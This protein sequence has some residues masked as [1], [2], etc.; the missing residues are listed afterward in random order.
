MRRM[1]IRLLT[2]ECRRCGK[3]LVTASWTLPGTEG[4]KARLDRIC[5]DC[6]TDAERRE[7]EQAQAAAVLNGGR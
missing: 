6:V 7:I 2:T 3:P 1:P 5:E 4:A